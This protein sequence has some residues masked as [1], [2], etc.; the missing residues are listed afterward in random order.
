MI[1][2]IRKVHLRNGVWVANGGYEYNLVLIAALLTLVDEGQGPCRWTRCAARAKRALLGTRRA[3][4]RRGDSTAVIEL[5]RRG[6]PPVAGAGAYPSEGDSAAMEATS[7]RPVALGVLTIRS[8]PPPSHSGQPPSARSLARRAVR[9]HR[10]A[11]RSGRSQ[12]DEIVPLRWREVGIRSGPPTSD[13]REWTWRP[14]RCWAGRAHRWALRGPVTPWTRLRMPLVLPTPPGLGVGPGG[15]GVV[16]FGPDAAEPGGLD[17]EP[18]VPIDVGEHEAELQ[19]IIRAASAPT[20]NESGGAGRVVGRKCAPTRRRRDRGAC[21]EIRRLG[22]W[23]SDCECPP[24]LPEGGCG[25]F[26]GLCARWTGAW[27]KRD[28]GGT[29]N[30]R[31]EAA[32][33]AAASRRATV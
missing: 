28:A 17:A 26:P 13:R 31:A 29:R 14:A 1:S 11:F 19:A 22:W 23:S 9:S 3:R 7:G 6:A 16:A 2:A 32:G 25:G 12:R 33:W 21:F 30:W 4:A 24:L 18:E 15:S 8:P 5:G 10:A 20:E 27:H